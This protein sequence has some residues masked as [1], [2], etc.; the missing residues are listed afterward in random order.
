MYSTTLDKQQLDAILAYDNDDVI[1]RFLDMFDVTYEEARDIFRETKK[2]LYLCQLK[3][4][5]IPDDLLILDE[6]WHNFI[7]FTREYQLFCDIHFKRYFHHLPASKK[8]KE[9]QLK[10]N[11]EDLEGSRNEYLDKLHHILNLTYDVL[12]DETVRKWF[13]LYPVK[14]SK[15]NIKM[16]RKV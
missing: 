5:F 10:K 12:G 6:M 3:G 7:L 11:N 13:Q 8:E 9:E 4:V 15:E 2:F 1:S 14:Y 16:L